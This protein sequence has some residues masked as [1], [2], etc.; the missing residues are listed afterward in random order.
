MKSIPERDGVVPLWT[1][2]KTMI[3]NDNYINPNIWNNEQKWEK[4]ILDDNVS[5]I[6]EFNFS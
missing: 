2:I 3:V 4:K 5:V 1:I 6:Y